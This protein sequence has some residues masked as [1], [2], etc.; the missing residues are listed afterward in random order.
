MSFLYQNTLLILIGIK[1]QDMYRK[2]KELGYT[3][4]IVVSVSQELDHLL[5]RYQNE[6]S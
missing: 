1:R 2:A 6:V 4:P 3:H 5:N